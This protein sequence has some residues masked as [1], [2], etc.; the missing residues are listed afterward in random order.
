M[1][2][3]FFY[4]ALLI[5]LFACTKQ[6]NTDEFRILDLSSIPENKTS[7]NIFKNIRHIKLETA[8]DI[9]LGDNL[10]FHIK[11]DKIYILD[12]S[13][14][15]ALLTFGGEGKFLGKTGKLGKG[16]EEYPKT[17]DFAVRNDTIDFLSSAGANYNIY[18]YLL[19]GPFL[20]KTDIDFIAGSFEWIRDNHYAISTN[21][22]KSLHDH[23]VYILD[24]NGKEVNKLHPNNTKLDMSVGENCFTV[25]NDQTYYYEP[26]NN[27]VYQLHTDTIFPVF[28]LDFG[29][30]NIP[31]AFFETDIMK[32]FE[33]INKQGFSMIKSVFINKENAVF[34]ILNQNENGSRLYVITYNLK[35]GNIKSMML[36]EENY[37]FRYPIGL[38]NKNEM[39]YLVFPIGDINKEFQKYGLDL[40]VSDFDEKDNPIV[41]YCKI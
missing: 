8:R 6:T 21:F 15:K 18:S 38:N 20:K 10:Y 4:I 37:I 14:Q 12:R 17:I 36:N 29:K 35:S 40:D 41:V 11:D 23:Q 26:F 16:P 2:K 28:E 25:F 22:Q 39:M 30:Y 24:N 1:K 33:M 9:M 5:S 27:K 31:Q 32:G 34:E 19:N 3:Q 7:E 13:H